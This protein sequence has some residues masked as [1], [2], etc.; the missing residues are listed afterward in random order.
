MLD[1][2]AV[3]RRMGVMKADFSEN[4]ARDI[5]EHIKAARAHFTVRGRAATFDIEKT[6]PNR[7]ILASHEIE[8]ALL[9]RMLSGSSK[10]YLM[11]ATIPQRAVDEISAA[12]GS[13][14]G[15]KAVVFDA[16]A[17]EYV[18]GALDVM[19][20]RKNA[21]L[22]RTAQKLTK[23]RFSA[24]YGD[25]D[26][27]YQKVFYDLLDMQTMNVSINDKCL[28]TPEKTVIAVAGVE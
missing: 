3:M 12:M 1:K 18:D 14:A 23:R 25:L 13:G 11:A 19:M 9:T 16:Y 28:L 5:D 6:A 2:K 20:E 26:I 24:G 15:L 21:M 7:F 27:G 8:S 17:S 10:V 22:K 4:L